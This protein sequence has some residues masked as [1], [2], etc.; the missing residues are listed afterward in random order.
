MS[1]LISLDILI[2]LALVVV[3]LIVLLWILYTKNRYLYEKFVAERKRFSLYKKHIEF[4]KTAPDYS[5]EDFNKFNQIVRAFFKE[6]HDLSYSLT[7]LELADNFTKQDKQDYAQFCR[8]MSEVNYSG[9]KKVNTEELR[10]LV[11]MFYEIINK[12]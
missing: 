2:P 4:L 12:Y 3:I 6:Y 7:Y 9:K 11:N 1:F 10:Y 8:L 5:I